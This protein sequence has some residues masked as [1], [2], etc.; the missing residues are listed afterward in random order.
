MEEK[1]GG[2]GKSICELEAST[3]GNPEDVFSIDGKTYTTSTLYYYLHYAY[4]CQYMNFDLIDTVMEIGSGSGKQIEIIKKLHPDICFYIFDMPLQLYVCEQYLSALFPNSVV[5]YEKTRL[6]KRIPEQRKGKIF[7]FGNWKLPE[8][9]DLNYDLFWNSASLQ[10]MEPDVALNY[11][12]YVNQQTN[13]YILLHECME[14]MQLAAKKGEHGVLEKTTL[15]HYKK[16]LKDFQVQ[17]LSKSTI[18]PT[19]SVKTYSLSFWKRSVE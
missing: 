5:S 12:K 4:C 1:A 15:E 19:A 13:K 6:M 9:T 2:G 10:E 16:G 11:L 17:D 7:I 8:L 18:L 3:I 14:G